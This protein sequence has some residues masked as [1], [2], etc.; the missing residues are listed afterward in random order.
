MKGLNQSEES[1]VPPKVTKLR[2]SCDSCL[3][4][5]VKCSKSRPI[6]VRCLSNGA[7]CGYSPSSRAGRKHRNASANEPARITTRRPSAAEF[8]QT[9]PPTP[10]YLPTMHPMPENQN[11]SMEHTNLKFYHDSSSHEDSR[12]SH[13]GMDE[14]GSATQAGVDP[15]DFFPTPPFGDDFAESREQLSPDAYFRD[16]SCAATA[17]SP[18]MSNT[19]HALINSIWAPH[20]NHESNYTL[21]YALP[22]F[23]IPPDLMTIGSAALSSTDASP[24]MAVARADSRLGDKPMSAGCDCFAVCLQALQTLHNHS[25]LPNSAQPGA[26]P[27]DVVLTIN[28]VAMRECATMLE[29]D[30]CV[31]KIGSSI[32]TMLLATIFGKIISLYGSACFFRFGASTGNQAVVKLAL[33]AY[34]LTGEDRRLLE[35]E[36]ILLELRKVESILLSYQ[37]RFRGDTSQ[38]EK[39]KDESGVYNAL[40]HYLEKNLRCILDFLQARKGT[41]S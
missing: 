19:S 24:K 9:A 17:A 7:A 26:L 20:E 3:S 34:T 4:A 21:P 40:T 23:Q 12:R 38:A 27:F 10:V 35:M 8:T 36:I 30:K 41:F 11:H 14:S 22:S 37:E 39:N 18:S 32:S 1:A 13:S 15:A 31:S 28:Q 5:K 25:W 33:G 2:E 16:L 29:C 6:C